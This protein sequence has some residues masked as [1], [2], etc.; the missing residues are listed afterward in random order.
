MT[1]EK[2]L[3]RLRQAEVAVQLP[4]ELIHQQKHIVPPL[5]QG[6]DDHRQGVQP[7]IEVPAEG[8]LPYLPFQRLVGGGH[9]A[10][11]HMDDVVAADPHDLP[12][13]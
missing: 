5:R 11:V 13:L 10:D 4:A 3:H 1:A 7:V 8:A 2:V 12:L 9:D 6:R